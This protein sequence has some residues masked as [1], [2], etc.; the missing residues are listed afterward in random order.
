MA[1][2]PTVDTRPNGEV[3]FSWLGYDDRGVELEIVAAITTDVR[4]GDEV[5]LVL[6]VMPTKLR[7]RQA[8]EE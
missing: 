6:H 4:S 2:S 7:T 1:G 5:L 8:K 3:E